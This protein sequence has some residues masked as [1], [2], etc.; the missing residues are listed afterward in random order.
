MKDVW[1]AERGMRSEGKCE[2]GM[3]NADLKPLEG[4]DNISTWQELLEDINCAERRG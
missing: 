3:R 4:A 2:C 1:S